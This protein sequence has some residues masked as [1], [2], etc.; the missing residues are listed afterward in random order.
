[1]EF[2]DFDF[3]MSYGL[4]WDSAIQPLL[5]GKNA[6]GIIDLGNVRHVA[7]LFPEAVRILVDA[8]LPTIERRLRTRGYNT[9]EQIQERLGNAKLIDAYRPY[10]DHVINN[11][12]GLFDTSVSHLRRIIT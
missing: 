3:G 12:D 10:Y 2:R 11:D 7:E 4:S 9:E 6:V 1:M 5:E 8:P